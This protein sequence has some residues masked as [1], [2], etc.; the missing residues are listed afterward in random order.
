MTKS[1]HTDDY[2]R[3][4]KRLR[5]ARKSAGLTQVKVAEKF[6][7]PQSYVAKVESGERQIDPIELGCFAKLYGKSVSYFLK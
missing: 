4:R 3:L 5:E 6:G 2:V 1:L 7:K